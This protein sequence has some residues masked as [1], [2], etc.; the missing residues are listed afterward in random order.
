MISNERLAEL[1]EL[2]NYHIHRYHVLDQ[3]E[4]A[5]AEY[6]ALF[7]EL[8]EI[9]SQHPDWVTPDSPIQ[10][11]GGA[12]A[13]HFDKV[14]HERAMLSLDK[15]TTSEELADWV[16]R[17]RNRLADSSALS[18]TCEPK[19]DGVAVALTYENGLLTLAATRGD[20][21]TGEDIT[22]NVRTIKSVPLKLEAPDVPPRFEV[23][24]EVYI[25]VADFERFNREAVARDEKPMINPRNGA[26]GSLR[27]LDSK[28]TASRP[29]AT[30]DPQRSDGQAGR[31]GISHQR[32]VSQGSGF[33]NLP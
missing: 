30:A 12:P 7:D 2:L 29:L 4:I 26:A 28:V 23:R 27:Q 6:D 1:R 13:S 20:G 8:L 18:F 21:Q 31:L 15:C 33:G 14:A 17:C 25:P 9:E 5:D 10:R 32:P 22:R 24:G 19:I 11:V 3:P 16:A